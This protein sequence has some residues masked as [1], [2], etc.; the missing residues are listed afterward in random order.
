M[1]TLLFI[2]LLLFTS[3]ICFSQEQNVKYSKKEIKERIDS[4][5]ILKEKCINFYKNTIRLKHNLSSMSRYCHEPR[6]VKRC[7][8]IIETYSIRS[9]YL[10][11]IE[12][13]KV[14]DSLIIIGYKRFPVV[15]FIICIIIRRKF[16]FITTVRMEN[17]LHLVYN[18]LEF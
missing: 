18:K 15:R 16:I 11:S 3:S 1:K 5:G 8:I 17:C 6:S 7:K 2:I 13:E 10:E 4:L 9:S 12:L 14:I